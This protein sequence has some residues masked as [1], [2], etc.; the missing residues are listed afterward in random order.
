MYSRTGMIPDLGFFTR[1]IYLECWINAKIERSKAR[2]A[3][4]R[5]CK[6]CNRIVDL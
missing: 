1:L 4:K 2:K 6:V 5:K 3:K